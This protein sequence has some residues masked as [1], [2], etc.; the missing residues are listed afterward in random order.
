M[1][2]ASG[3][4]EFGAEEIDH[5]LHGMERRPFVNHLLEKICPQQPERL[6]HVGILQVDEGEDRRADA[7]HPVV[8]HAACDP[9]GL[10]VFV[11]F[12]VTQGMC[13]F[14]RRGT[15]RFSLEEPDVGIVGFHQTGQC[16]DAGSSVVGI[17]VVRMETHIIDHAELPSLAKQVKHVFGIA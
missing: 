11:P 12:V 17:F 6:L 1:V 8:G 16:F 14:E 4:T 9:F 10:A 15:S 3:G 13:P 5:M 7:H 2:Q